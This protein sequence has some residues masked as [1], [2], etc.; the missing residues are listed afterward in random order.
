M[1]QKT[2]QAHVLAMDRQ[3]SQQYIRSEHE[4]FHETL[5]AMFCPNLAAD[6]GMVKAI[7]LEEPKHSQH[8]SN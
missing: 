2:G 4:K 3:K 7:E 6:L 5:S 8:K 1:M